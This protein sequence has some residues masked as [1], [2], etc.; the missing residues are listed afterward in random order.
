MIDNELSFFC[1]LIK[2]G[3]LV[4]AAR[5]LNLTAPAASRRLT[6]LEQRLGVRLL[7]RTTRKISLT[8]EGEI[9]YEHAS[10]IL[11]EI[12]DMEQ[13]ISSS[14]KKPTGIL[15]INAPLGFG[16]SYIA[17]AISAF[18]KQYSELSI[19]LHLTDRPVHLPDDATDIVV[20]FGK[21]PD[22]QLIAKKLI[23]NKRLICASPQYLQC[24]GIP[25]TPQDLGKHQCIVLRQNEQ[26]YANWRFVHD[27]QIETIKVHGALTTNDGE[28]AINWA[29][30]GHGILLRAQWDVNKYLHSGRLVEILK[31]YPTPDADVYAIY[32]ERLNR[33]PKVAV[34]LDYLSH[35]LKQHMSFKVG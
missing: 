28:V 23:N 30:D 14:R 11:D 17:P 4:A 19:Q 8:N 16:R 18:S 3:S 33:S 5:E 21:I 25:E 34:F 6:Q 26:A 22:S 7:N 2:H 32:L 27:Q 24:A 12:R 10:K 1:L 35:F 20:R 31:T 29:L 13:L 9:Y 15:R